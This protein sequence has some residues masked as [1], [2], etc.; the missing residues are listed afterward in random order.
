MST[1]SRWQ[2]HVVSENGYI[3]IAWGKSMISVQ[4]T[5]K[6]RE[7]RLVDRLMRIGRTVVLTFFVIASLLTFPNAIPWMAAFWLFWH[8][9]LVFRN[10]PGWLPLAAC[11]A[12]VFVK[13]VDWSPGLI[14]MVTLLLILTALRAFTA[15]KSQMPWGKWLA[16]LG[17]VGAWATWAGMT[18]EWQ[19]SAHTGRC[20][21]VQPARPVVCIG[22]SLT[23]FGYPQC[24]QEMISLRVVDL[25]C[26]G[27]TTG[28]AIGTLP[29]LVEANPQV[30]V[31]E[32]GGHDFL[33]GHSRAATREN[34]EKIIDTC[35]SIGAEV[36][37]MEIPRGF[38]T[39]PFGAL[40]REMARQERLEL[41]PDTAI[42][43]LVL[44]SPNAPPGMWLKRESRLSDDGLHPNARGNRMLANCVADALTR[45]YGSGVRV[46]P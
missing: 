43:G 15:R 29:S 18:Y 46:G 19:K 40:E 42:R 14:A 6:P 8:S 3:E 21:V 7:P 38:I 27:I 37:V 20:L 32:L 25:S 16:W 34:L 11:V 10:R 35:R 17:I 41:I 33:N 36:I 28:Q 31:I 24:L 44:W 39:D 1:A 30:V 5:E 2:L 23:A 12:I 9:L 26:S 13:R 22:D 4:Q 45:I